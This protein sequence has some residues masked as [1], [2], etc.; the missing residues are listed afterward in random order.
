MSQLDAPAANNTHALQR[1]GIDL[2]AVQIANIT[3]D[4]GSSSSW[5]RGEPIILRGIAT[6]LIEHHAADIQR[7]AD[8]CEHILAGES[9]ETVFDEPYYQQRWSAHFEALGTSVNPAEEQELETL[10]FDGVSPEHGS[11]EDLW[12]KIS[13]LSFFES[14][15]SLRFRFSFGEDHIEDVA[16]D[17][18]RQHYA[19][20]LA[21]VL[22]PESALITDN[23]ALLAKI[24]ESIDASS[25]TKKLQFVERIIYFNAPNGGA[26]LHHDL[27]RGHAGVVYVQA[28][29]QTCWIALPQEE[30][31]DMICDFVAACASNDTWPTGFSMQEIQQLVA[32]AAKR[33]ELAQ[34]LLSFAHD[35]LIRLINE[36][37]SFIEQ[38]HEAGH[39]YQLNTGDAILL[40]QQTAPADEPQNCCW[41]SVFCI[42]EQMGEGL[43]FA[44]RATD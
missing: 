32:L 31:L 6:P 30:L 33:E 5:I 41:H 14:D 4:V 37:P 16:A 36:S 20:Q 27:E 3:S 2:G 39:V 15:Q 34:A 43:S 11:I 22:F 26:Y 8:L 17:P 9:A 18:L 42:G 38:L 7:A 40:P 28:S 13:W 25:T 35:A 19:A 29:G 12:L 23:Q 44:I 10:F 24:A 21:Q 1:R